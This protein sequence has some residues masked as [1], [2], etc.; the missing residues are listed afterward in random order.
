MDV[1]DSPTDFPTL[2]RA[3]KRALKRFGA[4]RLA[5]GGAFGLHL[6]AGLSLL[7]AAVAIFA[8]IAAAMTGGRR[9]TVLD[10]QLALWFN[11]H[12]H[13][14]LTRALWLLTQLHSTPGILVLAA[15]L[16][17]CLYARKERYWLL[18]LSIAIPGGMLLNV[19]LKYLY[20]RARPGFAHPIVD[21]H[22]DTYS[23]P[24][25]HT[26]SATVLYGL[27]AAYFLCRTRRPLARAAIVLAAALMVAL[28]ALSR[29]YLGAHYL[30]DVLAACAESCAWLAV[31]LTSVSS[32]RR[33]RESRGQSTHHFNDTEAD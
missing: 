32:L 28:V 27:L 11:G 30:S 14:G 33:R 24:S 16:G 8:A 17:A 13:A 18:T 31:C 20:M 21:L 23:F 7:V 10:V 1:P 9:I 29:M 2:L 26:A 3:L 4:A 5:S 12:A 6:T 22:L 25:G 15:L 19:L